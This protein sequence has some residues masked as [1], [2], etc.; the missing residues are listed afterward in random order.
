MEK[1]KQPDHRS[2]A[3]SIVSAGFNKILEKHLSIPNEVGAEDTILSI[4]L[5]LISCLI[6]LADRENKI[7]LSAESPPPRYTND[8]LFNDLADIGLH[9]ENDQ[10]AAIREL[11]ETGYV[12]IQM[13]GRYQ[14][15]KSALTLADSINTVFTG[16]PGLSLIAYAIQTI[17]EVLSGRKELDHALDQFQQT[18]FSRKIRSAGKKESSNDP[19]DKGKK[20]ADGKYETLKQTNLRML[21]KIRSGTKPELNEPMILTRGGYS[22]KAEIKEIFPKAEMKTAGGAEDANPE[23]ENLSE[24]MSPKAQIDDPHSV[25]F[26]GILSDSDQSGESADT[27]ESDIRIRETTDRQDQLESQPPQQI[28]YEEN[29][30]GTGIAE[31]ENDIKPVIRQENKTENFL[32]LQSEEKPLASIDIC[33]DRAIEPGSI[34]ETVSDNTSLF[35]NENSIEKQIEAFETDLA[36]SCPLCGSGKILSKTT[37]KGKVYFVCSNESCN[38]ITWGRPYHFICP[39]CKNPFLIEFVDKEGNIGLKCPRST[40]AYRQKDLDSP[41][42][43][44]ASTVETAGTDTKKRRR[45]VVR[46]RLVLKKS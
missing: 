12:G 40:C 5:S 19:V 20:L 45:K 32:P 37:E 39:S 33:S 26:S 23:N 38:L 30:P 6:L 44:N 29:F 15:K 43:N 3:Y 46:K 1:E 36:M 4:N 13:D 14:A 11:V 21:S 35:T 34:P 28:L 18:L 2:S 24:E 9:A 42:K 41:S 22:G 7:N 10:I 17:E 25:T 8:S 31:A 16:M 27:P